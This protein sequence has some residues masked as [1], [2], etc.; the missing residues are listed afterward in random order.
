MLGAVSRTDHTRLT[1]PVLRVPW[2]CLRL[3]LLLFGLGAC[4]GVLRGCP[5]S[6]VW[7]VLAA[8]L[9]LLV[10]GRVVICKPLCCRVLLGAATTNVGS[11]IQSNWQRQRPTCCCGL[12]GRALLQLPP[13]A[14][15]PRAWGQGNDCTR[16][17]D[18]PWLGTAVVCVLCCLASLAE[19]SATHTVCVVFWALTRDLT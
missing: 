3:E 16:L 9:G 5:V 2:V 7:A 12:T 8:Q 1:Q 10:G 18:M 14:Y 17:G 15:V 4:T 11:W 6:A 13:H 19:R